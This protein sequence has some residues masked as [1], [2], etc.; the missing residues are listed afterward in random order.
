MNIIGYN[1]VNNTWIPTVLTQ[2]LTGKTLFLEPQLPYAYI[3]QT[4][5]LWFSHAFRTKYYKV[6]KTTDTTPYKMTCTSSECYIN[7]DCDDVNQYIKAADFMFEFS[8]AL[9]D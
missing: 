6:T 2:N 3:P 4:D 1:T 7:T 8:F 9:N 5:F